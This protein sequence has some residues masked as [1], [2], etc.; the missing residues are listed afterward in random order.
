MT[1]PAQGLRPSDPGYP[2]L[3]AMIPHPPEPLFA[4]GTLLPED[5]LAVALVGSRSP[6]PYGLA[7][8][9][10]LGRE[11]AE[12][13]VTV[14]SGLARGIDSAA[15]QG[16]LAAGGR[17]IAV[18]G[19]G[20]DVDYPPGSGPL[21]ARIA[22][23]GA[24]VTEFPPGFA[25]QTWTFPRRNRII[26]GL[27]LGVVVVEAG[28]K[29]GALITAGWAGD[30]GR[31]VMAV[32]GRVDN[33]AARGTYSLLRQG[34]TPV[35]CAGEV[36]EAVGAPSLFS[37]GGSAKGLPA[38]A[39]RPSLPPDLARLLLLVERGVARAEE[40]AREEGREI[41]SILGGLSRLE[42]EGLVRRD[43]GGYYSLPISPG[44]EV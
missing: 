5:S 18:L 16:A 24:I 34:A 41:S 36:L 40:M 35:S 14:V 11:L 29:S 17:T 33:L 1:P 39:P 23:S 22:A 26:S 44:R 30:Q 21:K 43:P 3:L 37:M 12:R 28:E 7:T 31:E 6:T 32:P 8:A 9:E 13:G 15:H 4:E 25:P 42:L 27:A 20:L 19:C 2:R 38:P 10:R